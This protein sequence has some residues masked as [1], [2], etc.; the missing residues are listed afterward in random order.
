MRGYAVAAFWR[1]TGAS[2]S[3]EDNGIRGLSNPSG[4]KGS[5]KRSR[6]AA[7]CSIK[8]QVRWT[9]ECSFVF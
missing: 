9:W 7:D 6:L 1:E 3:F 4:Q 2:V 8:R 5:R